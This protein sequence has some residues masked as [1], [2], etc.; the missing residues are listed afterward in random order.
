M[1]IVTIAVECYEL[2]PLQTNC[3]VVR[4]ERGSQ[5][6]VVVDPGGD[7]TQLRIELARMGASCAAILVT[8]GHWDH[9]LGVADLAEA[10][11]ARIYIGEAELELLEREQEWI[12]QTKLRS[13]VPDLRLSG[14]ETIDEA[15]LEI[16]VISSPGHRPG[17]LA[18]YTQGC[19]FWAT[20]S[21]VAR[22]GVPTLGVAIGRR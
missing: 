19:L 17:H 15:G 5:Q 1:T 7:V 3:F 22:S 18:F 9:V 11:G 14:G 13:F 2:G 4:S 10:T 16:E 6:A 20:S 8:H 12:G 21:S